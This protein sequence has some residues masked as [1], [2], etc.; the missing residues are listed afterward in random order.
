[1]TSLLSFARPS[2]SF[3]KHGPGR[4]FR[5]IALLAMMASLTSTAMADP[6]MGTVTLTVAPPPGLA[7]FGGSGLSQSPVVY[8]SGNI[9]LSQLFQSQVQPGGT[10]TYEGLTLT[11][12]HLYPSFG[13]LAANFNT[14][15]QMT[16]A[17]D[18]TSGSQPT[19]NVTGTLTGSAAGTPEGTINTGAYTDASATPQ[20]ATLQGWNPDSGVPM[21]L[22]NQYLNTANYS[23]YQQD[24]FQYGSP[25]DNPAT[26]SFAL[27][28]IPSA[29][30]PVPE[31]ATLAVFLAAIASLGFRHRARG[32]KRG[33]S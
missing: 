24:R 9:D 14:T 33:C 10:T 3:S 25:Q 16:I 6:V 22:I 11:G 26:G 27:I 20:A 1:V 19:I 5:L 29:I 21:S 17:F 15:F 7:G 31:P 12:A 23:L 8:S 2:H 32:A 30:T 13:G 18:G 4:S 28:A